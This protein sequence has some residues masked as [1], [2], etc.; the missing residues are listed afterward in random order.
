MDKTPKTIAQFTY[1]RLNKS[2][3]GLFRNLKEVFSEAFEEEL[4]RLSKT[5]TDQYLE[6]ILQKEN[7]ISLVA[8][9]G[10]N[11]VGGIV[12]YVLE[13][14]EQE[15][16]EIYLYDLAVAESFR[17]QGIARNL[18]LKLKEIGREI[19]VALIFVQADREDEPAIELYRTMSVETE[20][21]HFDITISKSM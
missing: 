14:Y 15:R 6:N 3:V 10:E 5:P 18:I 19:G 12:A 4:T 1:K 7:F 17:R 11:V 9:D 16:N 20:P 13:K 2:D 8:M 21:L